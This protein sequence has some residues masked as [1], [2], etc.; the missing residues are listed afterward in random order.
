MCYHNNF[1]PPPPPLPPPPPFIHGGRTSIRPTRRLVSRNRFADLLGFNVLVPQT[2]T[3]G[4]GTV[5]YQVSYWEALYAPIYIVVA[6]PQSLSPSLA[7]QDDQATGTVVIFHKYVSDLATAIV[8]I[9]FLSV[10]TGH[11]HCHVQWHGGCHSGR[12]WSGATTPG[13]LDEP[14]IP[15]TPMLREQVAVGVVWVHCTYGMS[16]RP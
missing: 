8:S 14:C 1:P 9:T 13:T 12:L 5:A 6:P 16:V 7:L 4:L 2:L 15:K 3:S 10:V 11:L